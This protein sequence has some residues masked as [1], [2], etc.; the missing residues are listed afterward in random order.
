[1][2]VYC[3]HCGEPITE[4]SRGQVGGHLL[5]HT[6]TVPPQAEPL[7]CYRLVTVYG[8]VLGSRRTKA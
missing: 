3:A 7:D 6:G 8:E 2:A 1:M 5:H 4:A